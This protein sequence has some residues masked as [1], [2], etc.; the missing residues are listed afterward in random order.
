M[1]NLN[2]SKSLKILRK[3]KYG[4]THPTASTLMSILFFK[5]M[6]F[7]KNHECIVIACMPKSGSTFLLN[8][9]SKL[10]GFKTYFPTYGGYRNE[11]NL[12]L[13]SLIEI[14][15]KKTVCQ[16]HLKATEANLKLIEKFSI[17][18][19]ILVRNIFDVVISLRDHLYREDTRGPSVWV[20]DEF[21]K[22]D[23]TLQIDFIIE[24]AIPWYINFYVSWF[25][26]TKEGIVNPIWLTY[27]E[28]TANPQSTLRLI[29]DSY[30]IKKS[31]EEIENT[32]QQV[33]RKKVRFNKGVLGRGY[34]TLTEVQI[35]RIRDFTRFY[36]WVDFSKIGIPK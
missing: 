18:P 16:L 9:L 25:S 29:M 33:G 11:Q 21:F 30:N 34:Q 14:Y 6:F 28:L 3:V 23:E 4:I 7:F 15:E 31:D 22:L 32:L 5:K 10:T 13:P 27:E 17:K 1:S 24:L 8:T 26:A 2:N 20:N 12:Y 35:Q 36:P 19:I